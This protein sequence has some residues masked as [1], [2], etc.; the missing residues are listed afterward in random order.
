M[1]QK[2]I[3]RI[4][5]ISQQNICSLDEVKN[6]MRISGDYDDKLIENLMDAAINISENFTKLTF[7][8]KEIKFITN[9]FGR[10][11]FDLKYS[12]IKEIKKIV[13]K[14]HDTSSTELVSD[15]YYIDHDLPSLHLV[16]SFNNVILEVDYIVG[17][18]MQNI[19][20]PIKHGIMMHVSE[21]YDRDSVNSSSL[22][23]GVKNL[24]MPY[25]RLS[26]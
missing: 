10:K 19:P 20:H 18:D 3:L 25:R 7:R 13:I 6:Y 11:S 22:S 17:F 5:K 26:I 15:E 12:P 23:L 8:E 1:F 21:M 24:Y 4:I 16:Q 9:V 14:E 2:N